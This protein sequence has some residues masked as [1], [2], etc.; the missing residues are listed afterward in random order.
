MS[1]RDARSVGRGAARLLDARDTEA[2]LRLLD[3]DPVANV[4]VAARVRNAGLDPWHLGAEVWGYGASRLTS[5]CYSGANLVPVSAGSDAIEAFAHRA[6]RQGRVCSSIVGPEN[7]VSELWHHL[8]PHWGPARDVRPHQP[9]M[10]TRR[11]A[12]VPGDPAVRLVRP[13]EV[14][15]LLPACVA[16]YTEEVGVSPLGSDGGALYRSRVAELIRLGRSYARIEDGEVLFKAEIGAVTPAACQVQGVWVTPRLRG[17][18]IGTAGMATV[19]RETLRTTAPAVSLYVNDF[20]RAARRAYERA[21]FTTIGSFAS[22][23]F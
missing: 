14:D 12:D 11:P 10:V 7:E 19:V 5:L 20:N 9:L 23:L 22:I 13:D 3:E 1:V 21:G 16:M 2:A 18:G 6:L 4:F 8:E 15:V 17:R